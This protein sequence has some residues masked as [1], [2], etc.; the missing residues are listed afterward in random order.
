MKGGILPF[1]I[2]YG[3]YK[4]KNLAYFFKKVALVKKERKKEKINKKIVKILNL[5]INIILCKAIGTDPFILN[6]P[7]H[8]KF[9]SLLFDR[10]RYPYGEMP[11]DAL[12]V[13]LK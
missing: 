7:R 10:F 11:T 1:F 3:F 2:V 8:H 5:S 4:L 6:K 12:K 13:L 9:I